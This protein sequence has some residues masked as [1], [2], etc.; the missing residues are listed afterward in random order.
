[1]T[2]LCGEDL[3]IE[4]RSSVPLTLVL[5]SFLG[6]LN[7]LWTLRGEKW[8]WISGYNGYN[9]S[10]ILPVNNVDS[11]DVRPRARGG[12]LYFQKSNILWIYGGL[13]PGN[14]NLVTQN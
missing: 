3:E 11:V 9:D 5:I 1:M 14:N 2:Y 10:G 13:S 4:V 6:V 7:D 8:I 12:Q